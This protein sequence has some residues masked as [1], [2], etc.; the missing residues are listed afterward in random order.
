MHGG[1]GNQKQICFQPALICTN[2]A[3]L[4]C[5]MQRCQQKMLPRS[6]QQ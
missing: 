6:Q 3:L 4:V 2:A 5:D 1:G